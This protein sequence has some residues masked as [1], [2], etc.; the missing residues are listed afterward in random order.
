[1]SSFESSVI[2]S[3][4]SGP[5]RAGVWLVI[6]LQSPCL[7]GSWGPPRRVRSFQGSVEVGSKGTRVSEALCMRFKRVSDCLC[8]G[9]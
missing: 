8:V 7:P 1:M 3:Q 2:W 4:G 6:R 9:T 5:A